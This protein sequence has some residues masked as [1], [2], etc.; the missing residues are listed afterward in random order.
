MRPCVRTVTVVFCTAIQL[1]HPYH[2]RRFG[3]SSSE[4]S[5]RLIFTTFRSNFAS[6]Q[7]F[8][9]EE[10]YLEC[11]DFNNE[12]VE[13]SRDFNL[14]TDR[15]FEFEDFKLLQRLELFPGRRKLEYIE[16]LEDEKWRLRWDSLEINFQVFKLKFTDSFPFLV[17]IVSQING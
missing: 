11:I 3:Y 6:L 14:T 9:E 12:L 17:R 13:E 10:R 8:L 4:F 1:S 16:R 7:R 5:H 15:L 2:I